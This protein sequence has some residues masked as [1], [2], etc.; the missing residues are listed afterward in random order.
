MHGDRFMHTALTIYGCVQMWF[1]TFYN[2]DVLD[3]DGCS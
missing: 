2:L 3:T 1:Y